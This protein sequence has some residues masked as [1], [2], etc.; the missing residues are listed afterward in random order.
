MMGKRRNIDISLRFVA[1]VCLAIISLVLIS[2]LLGEKWYNHWFLSEHG[3]VENATF[4]FLVV[5]VWFQFRSLLHYKKMPTLLVGFIFILLLGSIYFAG[6]ETDWGQVWFQGIET[7]E[8]LV[9]ANREGQLN[10]HKLEHPALR[11]MFNTGPRLLASI[12]MV[13]GIVLP[14]LSERKGWYDQEATS[15]FTELRWWLLPRKSI[16]LPC[17][18]ATFVSIASDLVKNVLDTAPDGYL[19]LV[20]RKPSGELKEYF[21]ALAIMIFS[22]SFYRR[23]ICRNAESAARHSHKAQD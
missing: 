4:L 11:L 22:W 15:L 9:S 21:I 19:E 5:A 3:I 10:L 17:V 14:F 1:A 16:V 8:A 2:P 12:L 23:L 6:E 20:L 13:V 7:P 18:L